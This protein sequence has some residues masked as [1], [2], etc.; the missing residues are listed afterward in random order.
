MVRS[1]L[2]I[3]ITFSSSSSREC[4]RF[5]LAVFTYN[6]RAGKIDLERFL[7]LD[8]LLKL[9]IA[10]QIPV[11]LEPLAVRISDVDLPQAVL[12]VAGK[13]GAVTGVGEFAFDLGH[14]FLFAKYL[15]QSDV[16]CCEHAVAARKSIEKN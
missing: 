10:C 6:E 9:D 12:F 2:A 1:F 16:F 15:S 7:Q 13:L 4:E 5:A 8:G 14:H 3:A 11:D